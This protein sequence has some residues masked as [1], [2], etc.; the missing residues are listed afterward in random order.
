[1]KQG[2]GEQS[3]SKAMNGAN[4]MKG[5]AM[6]SME[7]KNGE[8]NAKNKAKGQPIVKAVTPMIKLTQLPTMYCDNGAPIKPSKICPPTSRAK[9]I[10]VSVTRRMAPFKFSFMV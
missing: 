5:G 3:V 6:P 2:Q 7:A 10:P 9:R 8:T 1:M 4:S